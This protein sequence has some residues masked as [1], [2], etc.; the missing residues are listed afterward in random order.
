MGGLDEIGIPR[1]CAAPG[2][3]L[4]FR[5]NEMLPVVSPWSA[6]E[7]RQAEMYSTALLVQDFYGESTQI[8]EHHCDNIGTVKGTLM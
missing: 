3:R 6:A 1:L 4:S 2:T 7:L 8:M 5:G